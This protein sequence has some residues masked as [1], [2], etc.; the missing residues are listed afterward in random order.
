MSQIL[1]EEHQKEMDALL[2]LQT[3]QNMQVFNDLQDIGIKDTDKKLSSTVRDKTPPTKMILKNNFL[4]T[5][6]NL[7]N[8]NNF[9]GEDLLDELQE[10][11]GTTYN[12]RPRPLTDHLVFRT[13]K[14]RKFASKC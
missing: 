4:R 2:N 10:R 14:K 3:Q 8:E 13:K 7:E 9:N 12:H 11:P 1:K 5:F 6:V